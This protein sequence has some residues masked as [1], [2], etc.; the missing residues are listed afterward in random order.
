MIA[1]PAAPD[2]G[3]FHAYGTTPGFFTNGEVQQQITQDEMVFS[4][5]ERAG[6]ELHWL[7]ASDFWFRIPQ[8][9][10]GPIPPAYAGEPLSAGS[11]S[12]S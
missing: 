11:R 6:P 3:A 10:I 5:T 7:A 12:T 1:I 2:V 9:Y 4:I 8:A